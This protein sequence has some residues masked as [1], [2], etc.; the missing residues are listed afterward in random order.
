M[1][2][3]NE[4]LMDFKSSNSVIYIGTYFLSILLLLVETIYVFED[5]FSSLDF[6]G[7]FGIY[8]PDISILLLII[9]LAMYIQSNVNSRIK[10][11]R[12]YC[13][14][15]AHVIL[16]LIPILGLVTVLYPMKLSN[17]SVI[18]I[19]KSVLLLVDIFLIIF[20]LRKFET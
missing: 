11:S 19:S 10:R 18:Y 7:F 16:I 12:F 14:N 4:N 5:G 13:L 3:K 6:F 17:I 15:I 9:Y 20:T 1:K 2:S 8:L